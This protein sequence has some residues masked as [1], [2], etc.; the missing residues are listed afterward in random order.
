MDGSLYTAIILPCNIELIAIITYSSRKSKSYKLSIFQIR[1]NSY[2][3]LR[4]MKMKDY[5]AILKRKRERMGI[6][7]YRLAKNLG[8]SQTFLSEI[9]RGRKNPSLEQFFR[10]CEA[11][12]IQVFPNEE[13]TQ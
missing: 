6:S 7:Q 8:I 1:A 13:E 9:E 3:V 2:N 10:I 11:L 4:V 5:R 12:D